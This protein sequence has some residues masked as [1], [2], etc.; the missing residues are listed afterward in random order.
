LT[1]IG[2]L[3]GTL[4][5]GAAMAQ[6]VEAQIVEF[7]I[8]PGTGRGPWNTRETAVEVHI[9]DTLRIINDDSIAHQLHTNGAPCDH[10]TSMRPG[11][12]YDCF[13][14]FSL[15]PDVDGALYDHNVGEAAPFWLKTISAD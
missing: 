9:G 10:G 2:L 6:A 13:I 8:Q 12:H 11:G 15:D 1:T 3:F 5:S 4:L 14:Q 7:H